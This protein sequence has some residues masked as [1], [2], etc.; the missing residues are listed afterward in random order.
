[1]NVEVM[2]QVLNDGVNS[3]DQK[4]GLQL[5]MLMGHEKGL[6]LE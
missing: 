1:M 6:R 2:V 3:T 5:I 4:P